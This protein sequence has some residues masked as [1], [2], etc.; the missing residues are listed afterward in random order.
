MIGK[1]RRRRKRNEMMDK[2][3]YQNNVFTPKVKAP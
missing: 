2:K 1:R 3:E